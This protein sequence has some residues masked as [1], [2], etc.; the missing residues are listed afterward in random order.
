MS[1]VK[2]L[3]I[4]GKEY[5]EDQMLADELRELPYICLVGD[6]Y[7]KGKVFGFTHQK[8]YEHWVSKSGFS[9]SYD[10]Q[11][12]IL[13]EVA[14]SPDREQELARQYAEKFEAEQQKFLRVLKQNNVS[15][16]DKDGVIRLLSDKSNGL[17]S[18]ILWQYPGFKGAVRYLPS[19]SSLPNFG[20]VDF[21]NKASSVLQDLGYVTLFRY[22]WYRGRAIVLVGTFWYEHLGDAPFHFNNL[23]SSSINAA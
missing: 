22:T 2:V 18:T 10:Q 6:E 11:N 1:I 7:R 3:E 16:D 20:W 8:A 4:D 14:Y 9:K 17:S 23:A 19:L 15:S 12:E 13:A 5:T 21:D